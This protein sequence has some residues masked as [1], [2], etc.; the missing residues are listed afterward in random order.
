MMPQLLPPD[1]SWPAILGI[2]TFIA[3]LVVLANSGRLPL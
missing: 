2:V 1:V 3:V